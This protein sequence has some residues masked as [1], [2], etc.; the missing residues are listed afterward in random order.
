MQTRDVK[1]E[2]VEENLDGE[3]SKEIYYECSFCGDRI[4]LLPFARNLC[5]KLCGEQYFCNFCLRNGF[6]TRNNRHVLTLTFRAI[7]GYYHQEFYLN[8]VPFSK[9]LYLSQI[10]EYIDSHVK[11]GLLNPVFNYNPATYLWFIDFLKVGKGDKKIRL[12]DVLKTVINIIACFNLKSQVVN[13]STNAIFEK[14]KEA[15]CKFY[16]NRYRPP[17]RCILAPTISTYKSGGRDARDF[18]SEML[19]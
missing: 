9:K 13:T 3:L 5:D 17:G 11:A 4:A 16:S 2:S 8:P 1:L 6:H 15:I 12:D 10:Q 18:T 19:V 14:Y 7:I